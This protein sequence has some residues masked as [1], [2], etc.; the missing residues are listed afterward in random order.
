MKQKITRKKLGEKTGKTCQCEGTIDRDSHA[1]Y[2]YGINSDSKERYLVRD[3]VVDGMHV[4]H[5]WIDCPELSRFETG[6]RVSFTA[7]V[8]PYRNSINIISYGLVGVKNLEKIRSRKRR[9]MEAMMEYIVK[10]GQV[11]FEMLLGDFFGFMLSRKGLRMVLGTLIDEGLLECRKRDDDDPVHV[12]TAL[13]KARP[14]I[15]L[16]C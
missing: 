1:E 13:E 11:T 2:N 14:C 16:A 9:T 10:H 3:L 12:Y 4:E 6:S 7:T 5:S 8:V 15:E